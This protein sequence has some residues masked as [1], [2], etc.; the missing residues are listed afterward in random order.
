M[1]CSVLPPLRE[2]FVCSR[3]DT[4]MVE[5]L[6]MLFRE[7][8]GR[9]SQP[10]AMILDSRNLQSTPESGARAGYDG[11][12]CRKGSKVHAAVDTL[13]HLLALHVTAADELALPGREVGRGGAGNHWRRYRTGLRGPRLYRTERCTRRLKNTACNW[14][15]SSTRR[16]NVVSCYCPAAGWWSEALPGGPLPRTGKG[17]RTA[18]PNPRRTSYLAFAILMLAKFDQTAHAKFIIGASQPDEPVAALPRAD[19]A[20]KRAECGRAPS[21]LHRSD[22]AGGS[23]GNP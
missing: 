3:S 4:I 15:Q 2:Q 10:A 5:D 16:P 1:T 22:A 21:P 19:R 13:G 18:L 7:F 6:R 23:S 14:R 9:K 11:A 20:A 17:L 12:K 8:A